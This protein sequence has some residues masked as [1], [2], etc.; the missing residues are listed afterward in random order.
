MIREHKMNQRHPP[1][2]EEEE[3]VI[4]IEFKTISVE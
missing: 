4:R 3:E 2:E 1:R